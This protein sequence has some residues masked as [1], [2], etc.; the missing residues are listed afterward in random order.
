MKL[1]GRGVKAFLWEKQGMRSL[2]LGKGLMSHHHN[3]ALYIFVKYH[4][5]VLATFL[6]E[7]LYN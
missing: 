1:N 7:L 4:S 5:L 2:N 3:L 6:W